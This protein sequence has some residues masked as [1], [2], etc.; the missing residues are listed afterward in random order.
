MAD[1]LIWLEAE[2]CGQDW[3]EQVHLDVGAARAVAEIQ[4]AQAAMIQE[5]SA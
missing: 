1:A 3:T 2:C 5:L 4:A